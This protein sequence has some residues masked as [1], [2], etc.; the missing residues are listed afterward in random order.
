VHYPNA[1]DAQAGLSRGAISASQE[2][3]IQGA[4][5]RGKKPLQQTALGGEILIH[6][7]GGFP[8]WTLGCVALENDDLDR[9]RALLAPEMQTDVLILP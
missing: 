5:K 9:L 4:L 6:G 2:R 3:Q 8:D 1:L 7:G